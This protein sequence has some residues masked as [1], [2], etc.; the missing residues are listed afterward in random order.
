MTMAKHSAEAFKAF[1]T[2][3]REHCEAFDAELD[4]VLG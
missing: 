3:G 2:E 1:L 4:V